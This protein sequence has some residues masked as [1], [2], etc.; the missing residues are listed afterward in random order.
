MTPSRAWAA[1][2]L[3][4]RECRGTPWHNRCSSQSAVMSDQHRRIADALQKLRDLGEQREAAM[5]ELLK[6]IQALPPDELQLLWTTVQTAA[7][8][9]AAV[10][11]AEAAQENAHTPA[12]PPADT[13]AA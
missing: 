3:V 12:S 9:Q 8:V 7:K 2:V 6:E 13:R 5:V 10:A 1:I 11:E 4:E